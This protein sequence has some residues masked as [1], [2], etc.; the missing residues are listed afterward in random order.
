MKRFI[1]NPECQSEFSMKRLPRH[2]VFH[3]SLVTY[4]LSFVT[5]HSTLDTF[6]SYK[7]KVQ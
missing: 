3:P 5:R 1:E 7:T 6:H 4:F 2:S